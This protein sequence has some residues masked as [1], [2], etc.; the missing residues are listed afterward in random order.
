MADAVYTLPDGY[1]NEAEFLREAREL[2]QSDLDA[3]R[4]NRL[5]ALDDLKFACNYQAGDGLQHGAQWDSAV[6]AQREGRPCLTTNV[7]PQ[8]I[9]QVIG[10]NRINRPAIKVRPAEDADEDL[11]E[12]RAGLIRSIEYQS[13]AQEIYAHALQGQATCGIGHF[14]CG[15]EYADSDT[16]LRDLRIKKIADHLSV[17]WDSMSVELT[18]KDADRC[19]VSDE[20]PRKAFEKRW[21]G[22]VPSNLE[23]LEP[24]IVAQNWITRDTVRVTEYWRMEG[25][26]RRL[27]MLGNDEIQDITDEKNVALLDIKEEREITRRKACMWLIT[28]NAVLEGPHEVPIDR[29]PIFRCFGQVYWVGKVRVWFG[30]VRFMKDEQRLQNYADSVIAETLALAPKAQWTGPASAFSGRE[31]EFRNAHRNGDPLLPYNDEATAPPQRVDPPAF[32]VALLQWRQTLTQAMK[33]VSGLHD[34]S[35][36]ISS[37]ETSGKAIMAR[38]REGDVATIV[39]HD[40]LNAAIGECGRVLNQ[41]IP[42]IYDTARTI[43]I[44]GEDETAK[45]QRIN[46]PEDPEAADM[47]KGKYDIVVETGPSYSTKRVEAA[48]SMIQ[49]VQAF[50]QAAAVTGDLIAHAQ[51]WP[52]ADKFAERLKSLLPPQLQ[53]QKDPADMSAEEQQEAQQRQ[54]MMAQQA[55]QQQQLQE[56]TAMLAIEEGKAKIAEAKARTAKLEAEAMKVASET[57]QP[58]ESE[59]GNVIDLAE[60][61]KAMADAEKAEAD[62]DTARHRAREAEA[63]AR[64]AEAKAASASIDTTFNA[65]DTEERIATGR[66]IADPEPP[67]KGKGEAA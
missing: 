1:E 21:P 6:V 39:Y 37:N 38:Q 50:P 61:R 62:A 25:E 63:N 15:L 65:L 41:L 67:A 42:V 12:V 17:V 34:A 47:S 55:Q 14:R 46:D 32:P 3:D 28:G 5:A 36:G 64:L 19:F 24:D 8:Y 66:G 4:I 22:K 16:F 29:I 40:N 18:G 51:D 43:R 49:F 48:E 52:D 54:A 57:G 27:A 53:E 9:G 31:N 45:V 10:D 26:K 35:L 23:S 58:E 44:V 20:M 13:G 11:A 56:I 59:G 60:A 33:D 7:L 30:L 2:F